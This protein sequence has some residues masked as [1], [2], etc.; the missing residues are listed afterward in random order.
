MTKFL[1]K[2]VKNL[3]VYTHDSVINLDKNLEYLHLADKCLLLAH[4]CSDY[5]IVDTVYSS[6]YVCLRNRL[7]EI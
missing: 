6:M 3:Y 5:C 2:L 4:L 7:P 1:T